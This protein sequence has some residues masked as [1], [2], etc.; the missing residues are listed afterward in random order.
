[1]FNFEVFVLFCIDEFLYKFV[2][3][4]VIYC[5]DVDGDFIVL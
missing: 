2:L 1:M 5:F 4:F 3:K